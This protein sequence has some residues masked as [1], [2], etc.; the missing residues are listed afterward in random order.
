MKVLEC[1]WSMWVD[2][3]ER[4]VWFERLE[5]LLSFDFRYLRSFNA[6]ESWL[7]DVKLGITTLF[8]VSFFI[9]KG[10]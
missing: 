6:E 8:Y 5:E 9:L 2:L 1:C 4:R 10:D 3:G 7:E